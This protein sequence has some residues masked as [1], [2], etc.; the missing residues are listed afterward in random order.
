MSLGLKLNK[1]LKL[2][3]K[4]SGFLGRFQ[5]VNADHQNAKRP[6]IAGKILQKGGKV[7]LLVHICLTKVEIILRCFLIVIRV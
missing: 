1:F 2:P 4:E 7:G 6:K 3:L 5:P